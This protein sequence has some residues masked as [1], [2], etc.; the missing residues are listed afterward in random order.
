MSSSSS[1][2]DLAV[3][4]LIASMEQEEL[5]QKKCWVN[6]INQKR[7][8]YG[9]FHHL[10]S[11]L[12]QDKKRF[13]KYFRMSEEKFFELLSLLKSSI[14]HNNTRFRKAV[15]IEERLAVCLR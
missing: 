8:T 13:F 9:E 2:E 3:L 12:R 4:S 1:E 7:L 14:E 6:N 11:D 10:F 15:S 5:T